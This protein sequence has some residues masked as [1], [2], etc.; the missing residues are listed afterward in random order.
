MVAGWGHRGRLAGRGGLGLLAL[1]LL[2]CSGGEVDS[3]GLADSAFGGSSPTSGPATTGVTGITTGVGGSGDG[4][5][6]T[7]G[8]GFDET[9][10]GGGCVDADGDGFGSNCA[11]GPDCDD[12]NPGAWTDEGCATCVDGDG[13]GWF[14][15]C[16]AYPDGIQGPDCDDSNGCVWT[17]LGCDSCVDGDEDGVWLGCDQYGDCAPG[18]DCDDGNPAVGEGDAVEVCNGVAENCAGEIDPFPADQMCPVD[19]DVTGWACDPPSPGEDGCVITSCEVDLVDLDADP[20][21]GCECESIPSGDE[22]VDCANPID[23]GDLSDAASSVTVSG[24]AV[25]VGRVIWYRFRG[26]DLADTSCDNY[27]VRVNFLSNPGNQYAF[28]VGRG[29]CEA[30]NQAVECV[31]Y[32]WATDMRMTIDGQLTGQCPCSS[33]AQ[34][35]TNVSACEN[36]TSEYFVAVYRTDMTGGDPTCAP[37]QLAISNGVYDTP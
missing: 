18:P 2:G 25:P 6:S 31:D 19:P 29:S 35:P 1:V 30:A 14:G 33:A 8:G 15:V 28:S 3:G 12:A 9:G 22:G 13:D 5:G 37:Y 7:T 32:N 26:V 11:G 34:P 23:V 10:G 17:E 27:H 16:D 21:T 4:G 20:V 36:D 24:N